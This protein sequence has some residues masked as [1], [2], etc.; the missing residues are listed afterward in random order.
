MLAM[1][2]LTGSLENV[3]KKTRGNLDKGLKIA[4]D[5]GDETFEAM[6]VLGWAFGK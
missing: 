3:K 6:D 2:K 4:A 5:D 1:N